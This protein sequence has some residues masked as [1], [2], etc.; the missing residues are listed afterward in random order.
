MKYDNQLRY[1]VN[2]VREYDGRL[3]L[4]SWLK[5][6]FREHKQMGSRD[7]KT[8]AEMV[9]GFYR[10][11]HA[12]FDSAGERILTGISLGDHFDDVKE[13]FGIKKREP[14]PDTIKDIFPWRQ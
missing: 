12:V 5:N 3:P 4:A 11:G 6:F 14:A 9:Y 10:L 7:R 1:A 13:Y 8:V 2:I